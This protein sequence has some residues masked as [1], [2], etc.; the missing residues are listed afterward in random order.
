MTEQRSEFLM[1]IFTMPFVV[2]I[3]HPMPETLHLSLYQSFESHPNGIPYLAWSPDDKYIVACG[4]DESFKIYIWNVETGDLRSKIL[5]SSEDSLTSCAWH[6]DGNKF[7]AGGSR[8]HFYQCAIIEADTRKTTQ[9]VAEELNVDQATIVRHLTQIGKV[10]KLDKW[11]P[12]DLNDVHKNRCFEMP[13]ALLLP[14]KNKP[15]FDHIVTLSE[16]QTTPKVGHDDCLVVYGRFDPP[17]LPESRRNHHWGVLSANRSNAPKTSLY[18][19]E[20]GQKKRAYFSPQQCLTTYLNDHTTKDQEGNVLDSWEGVRILC[21]WCQSDNKTVLAADTHHRIRAYN[22]EDLSDSNLIQET[23]SIMS[24][25]CNDSGTYA[26]LNVATQGL[27]LWDLKDRVLMRKFQGATPGYYTIHS[28]FGGIDQVY[29]ASG[30]EDNKVYIWHIDS[31]TPIAVLTGHVRTVNCV[32]WNPRYPSLLASASDDGTVRIWG[33]AVLNSGE[34]G[35]YSAYISP[36]SLGFLKGCSQA[37]FI[38]FKL[39]QTDRTL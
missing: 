30:S 16:A 25:T 27:H 26:L 10:K 35:G 19:P 33:P 29:V 15:F 28:C 4:P 7:V 1:F 23:N 20:I 12:H 38:Y 2:L 11:V 13:A 5:H 9:E 31:E 32:T 18:L 34:S 22:F 14:N 8:G 3:R 6:R 39:G 21:L 37:G 24:F 17:Q 36:S